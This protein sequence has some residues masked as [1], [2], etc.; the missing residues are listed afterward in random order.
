M[1]F[2]KTIDPSY[3]ETEILVRTYSESIY[4]E[5]MNMLDN[6]IYLKS[7]SG[8]YKVKLRNIVYIESNKNYLE[9][10]VK[11]KNTIKNFR[12]R[13]TLYKIKELLSDDFIQISRTYIINYNF[14]DSVEAD[15]IHGMVA[16]VMG[17]KIPIS[18]TYLGE[19]YSKLEEE[20]N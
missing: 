20:N 17:F 10:Y 11:E 3:T 13:L 8:A 14:L 18:R 16:R 6:S 7:T 5:I 9:V 1:K 12:V 2:Q 15:L 19:I 4:E